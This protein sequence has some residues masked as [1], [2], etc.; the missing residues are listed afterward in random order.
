MR[1][2]LR[3]APLLALFVGLI[4]GAAADQAR[5]AVT[6]SI[7]PHITYA[8]VGETIKVYIWKDLPDTIFDGY[9]TIITYNPSQLR[10]ISAAEETVMTKSCGN[11]WWYLTPASGTVFISHVRMCPPLT[12]V[13]GPGALSSLKF[14]VL[15]EGR[16]VIS[17]D[18][19]WFTREGYWIKNTAWEDGLVLVGN[20]GVDGNA[21]PASA[22]IKVTPNPGTQFAFSV[23]AASGELEIHDV[24]GRV[25]RTLRGTTD[26]GASEVLTWD[27]TDDLNRMC[28]PGVYF[29]GLKGAAPF[30]MCPIVLVR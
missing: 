16:I 4:A 24:N 20:A 7:E 22:A 30:K 15:A 21:D 10:Y 2:A 28:S 27:G 1:S 19:F 14:K 23:G 5:A 26:P 25:V 6:I 12:L 17:R 9:E 3:W 8:A 11:R 13:T 29:A 18:Y